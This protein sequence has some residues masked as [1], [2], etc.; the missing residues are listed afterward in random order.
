M[1]PNPRQRRALSYET[2]SLSDE[3]KEGTT[4]RVAYVATQTKT[5]ER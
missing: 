2:P 3:G 4:T 5:E 1:P